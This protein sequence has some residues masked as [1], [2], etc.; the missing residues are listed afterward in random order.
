MERHSELSELRYK[1]LAAVENAE[2]VME[3]G[4]GELLAVRLYQPGKWLVVVYKEIDCDGFVI[5]AYLTS[6][7]GSLQRRKQLWP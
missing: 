2:R 3:G 5:T 6:K 7:E 1:V 4:E